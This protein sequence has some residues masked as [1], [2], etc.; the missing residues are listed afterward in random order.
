MRRR[1]SA[2]AKEIGAPEETIYAVTLA[3]SETVTNAVI[4]AY[5]GR[6][7]GPV[8]VRCRVEGEQLLVEVVDE[9]S[10]IVARDDSPGVGQGLAV[11]GALVRTLEIRSGA[12]GAGTV[13][14][15]AFGAAA[16][17]PEAPGLEPLC[18]LALEQ[19]ADVSVLDVLSGGVLRRVAAEVAGDA[20]LTEWL[21]SAAPPARPGTATWQAMREGGTQ[22]V[23]HDPS[24]PRA[25]GGTGEQLGLTWWLAVALNGSAA[26]WGL[27]GREGGRPVPSEAVIRALAE[28]ADDDLAEETRRAALRARLALQA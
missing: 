14:R 15:M 25:P 16:P 21:S 10:G 6:E 12:E 22:L 1:V 26:L 7:P 20:A 3:V 11:V 19:V 17:A 13:V 18:P 23:V 28:A 4:H 5:A 27:G 2:F 9:G 24:V 8:A